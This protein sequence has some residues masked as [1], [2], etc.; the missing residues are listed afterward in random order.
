[1]AVMEKK[2]LQEHRGNGLNIAG[3]LYNFNFS[4]RLLE[5]VKSERV[6]RRNR[7]ELNLTRSIVP[8]SC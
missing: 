1:M 7:L 2:H 4:D 3:V 6:L 8:R 5:I